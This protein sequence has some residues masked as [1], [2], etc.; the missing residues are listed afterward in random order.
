MLIHGTNN[1]QSQ[2]RNFIWRKRKQIY[3]MGEECPE[4]VLTNG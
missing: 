2:D 4:L 3:M 1:P